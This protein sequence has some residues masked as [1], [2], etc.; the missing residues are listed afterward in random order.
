M[1]ASTVLRRADLNLLPALA[2]LLEQRHVTRAA[3]S[4]G[5]GQPAMSAALAR[6]RRLFG[7]PLLVRR[8][9]V[10]ELTPMGQ[11]LLEPVHDVL[12]SLEHLLTV[13]PDFDPR[14]DNRSFT[15][16]ASDYVTLVLLRSLFEELYRDAPGVAVNV[17]PINSAT[18]LAVERGQVDL[19]ILPRQVASA[20][21]ST[22]RHRELFTD[23]YLPAVWSQ[24]RDVGDVLDRDALER[25]PYV[26]YRTE[27]GGEGEGDAYIDRQLA[28]LGIHPRI[29]LTTLS[30]AVIPS[31]LPGTQLLGF[32]HE[33]LLRLSRLQ[34]ELR[35]LTTSISFEPIVESMYW[36]PVRHSDPAH[37]W[38]RERITTLA[39]NL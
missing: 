34:R 33:R 20:R 27:G 30:F 16:A 39:A 25:L 17:M 24:N 21:M 2:A 38:L 15:V 5:I 9:R 6:L 4:I 31:L 7:D 23:R 35:V 19:A 13:S 18:T 10:L 12:A 1:D 29:A 14:T 37:H 8:G 26:C 32:V 3:E 22:M 11:A 36:H 28:A